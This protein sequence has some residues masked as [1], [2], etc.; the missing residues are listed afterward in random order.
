MNHLLQLIIR[1]KKIIKTP[2]VVAGNIYQWLVDVDPN[3]ELF[4][5]KNIYS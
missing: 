3:E 4:D 1:G 2:V 5:N